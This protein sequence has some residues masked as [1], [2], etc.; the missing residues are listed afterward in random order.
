MACAETIFLLGCEKNSDVVLGAAYGALIKEYNEVL[1]TVALLKHTADEVLLST[2]YY[3]QK[4]FNA[5]VGITTLPITASGNYGPVYR[6]AITDGSSTFLKMVNYNGVIGTVN[7]IGVTVEGSTASS[8][9]LTFLTA[10]N[11]TSVN[12]LPRLGGESTSLTTQ[13]ISGS[14]GTFLVV[15]TEAYE[16]AILVV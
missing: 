12:N 15:F 1:E 3:V 4:L 14:S 5:P 8:A 13:T 10:P 11:D 2:S 6:S 9:Q 7:A 16:I